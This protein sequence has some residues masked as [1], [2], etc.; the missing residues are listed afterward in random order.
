M[1]LYGLIGYPL[2]HSFSKKYFT[3]KFEKENIGGHSYEL[4][5]I[6]SIDKLVIEVL[7]KKPNLC[8]LNVT[9]PYKK[10]VIPFLTDKTQLPLSACNCIKITE[11]KLKGFNTDVVGFEQSLITLLKPAHDTAMIL[12][13]GGAA[14]AVKYV[15]EKLGIAYLVASRSSNIETINYT[16][17]TEE[18]VSKHKLIINCTPLGTY[19]NIYECPPIPYQAITGG[20]YLFDLV[21]NPEETLF[22]K[23]GAKRGALVKNGY[24][25]LALQAEES[26]RIWNDESM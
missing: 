11:G 25:M 16:S 15:L 2:S 10:S 1:K 7:S 21:Y 12:G 18:I 14:E 17:I 24:D 26:W 6:E 9:I 23:E 19:P 22:L 13:T 8:G 5:S 4:F 3:E 20:H